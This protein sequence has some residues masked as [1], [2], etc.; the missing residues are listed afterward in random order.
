MKTNPPKEGAG[1]GKATRKMMRER[2]VELAALDGR[3]AQEASKSD[4]EQA[5]RELMG[6]AETDPNEAAT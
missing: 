4:W 3:S 5:K 6:E 1:I 2:A